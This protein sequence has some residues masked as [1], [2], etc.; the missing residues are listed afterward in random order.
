MEIFSF[1]AQYG[2]WAWVVGGLILLGIELIVPGGIFIWL[3]GAAI[4]TG[5][6]NFIL[7]MPWAMQWAVFGALSLIAI[8][9][10]LKFGRK[11]MNTKTDTPFLNKRAERFIGREVILE[12]AIDQGFGRVKLDDTMWRVSGPDL[13]KGTMVKIVSAKSAVLE[14]EEIT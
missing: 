11:A 7:P 3:G 14:V 4:A 2:S 13:K 1:L 6:F 10:W 5:L 8:I 9:I 12:K